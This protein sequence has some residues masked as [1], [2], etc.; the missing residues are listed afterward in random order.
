MSGMPHSSHSWDTYCIIS[1]S[2]GVSVIPNS[3]FHVKHLL[4]V[5][6]CSYTVLTL[7]MPYSS[8]PSMQ[9]KASVLKLFVSLCGFI[10]YQQ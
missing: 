1:E 5:L 7:R 8:V 6:C 10:Y 4:P 9:Y 3:A 2:Q